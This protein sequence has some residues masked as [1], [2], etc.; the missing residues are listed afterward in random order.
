MP[1]GTQ[2]LV[3]HLASYDPERKS[4]KERLDDVLGPELARKLV[5]ALSSGP[6]VRAA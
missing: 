6:H 3:V 5:S 4:A 1:R 2:L